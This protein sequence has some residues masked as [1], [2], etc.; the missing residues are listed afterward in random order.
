MVD[1]HRQLVRQMLEAV[2]Y[3]ITDIPEGSALSADL[4]ASGSDVG[5]VV[6]V[7]ARRDDIERAR[8]FRAAAPGQVV[9]E[10][11]PVRHDDG[12]SD[13][14]HHAAKQIASSQRHYSGLGVLW[15]RA[16]PEIGIS[17]AAEKLVRTLLGRR[18]VNVRGVDGINTAPCY[19]AGYADFYHYQGIDLAVVE[20][21]DGGARLLVNP[22]SSR[23]ADVRATRLVAFVAGDTPGAVID[24]HRLD[25]PTNGYVLWGEFCRKDEAT[26]LR[27]LKQRYPDRDFQLFDMTSSIGHVWMAW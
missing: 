16:D 14:I 8:E 17:H 5:L 15:F 18:Y 11:S 26:V 10:H 22:F 20:D 4:A 7:K 13:I 6:E 27:E 9:G 23:I 12:L 24:L 1:R 2:C 25:T 3:T 21:S 19:L